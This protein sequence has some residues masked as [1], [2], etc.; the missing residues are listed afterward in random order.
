MA[1]TSVK[2]QQDV[3]ASTSSSVVCFWS[4]ASW[5]EAPPSADHPPK[6]LRLISNGPSFIK[7]F[8]MPPKPDIF[9][10]LILNTLHILGISH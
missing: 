2:I 3:L 5:K 10:S 8:P 7:S 1:K 6:T 4:L 9:S